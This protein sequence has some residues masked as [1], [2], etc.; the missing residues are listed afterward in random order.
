MNRFGRKTLTS[1]LVAAIGAVGLSAAVVAPSH[2]ATVRQHVSGSA[3]HTAN[4]PVLRYGMVGSSVRSAQGDLR[5][6]GYIVAVDGSFGPKML[7]AVKAFQRDQHLSVDGVIGPI[8]WSH[9][10]HPLPTLG[11]AG[12]GGVYSN[13]RGFGQ[14]RPALMDNG[15]DA[16]GLVTE[17]RW[18]TWGGTTAGGHGISA[19]VG[20]GEPVAAGVDTPVTVRAYDLTTCGG[21]PAY[22]H[23]TWWF[24]SKGET[25]QWA[26]AH[27]VEGIDL[28]HAG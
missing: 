15:G 18:D 1:A 21:R 28:C 7:A 26:R 20:A 24:P 2:A 16:T 3:A 12:F 14:A 11:L 19:Y 22:R 17:V 4:H 25:Y 10:M 13:T 27:H 9:L 8:T 23:V 5:R 6:D